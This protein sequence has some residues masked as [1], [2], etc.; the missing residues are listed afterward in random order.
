MNYKS[1]VS[2]CV[3][4]VL[5]GALSGSEVAVECPVTSARLDAI[6]SAAVWRGTT[7]TR[8]DVR[9]S[10]ARNAL[11]TAGA[12]RLFPFPRVSPASNHGRSRWGNSGLRFLLLRLGHRWSVAAPAEEAPSL[13]GGG[14]RRA[15]GFSGPSVIYP[16][17][18]NRHQH[19]VERDRTG[20][21]P[22]GQRAEWRCQRPPEQRR[23]GFGGLRDWFGFPEEEEESVSGGGGRDPPHRTASARLRT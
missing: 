17:Q 21:E 9:T 10:L 6:R 4:P 3:R 16:P 11:W 5:V 22:P 14:S 13:G 15:R 1:V 8:T 19:A 20:A 7:T 18:P 23:L 2:F 12:R